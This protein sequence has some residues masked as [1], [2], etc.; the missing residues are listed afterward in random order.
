MS[1]KTK[2]NGQATDQ[3][4]KIIVVALHHIKLKHLH[5]LLD[6]NVGVSYLPSHRQSHGFQSQKLN[7]VTEVCEGCYLIFSK[8][9]I[10]EHILVW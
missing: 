2:Q 7:D 3:P 4:Q 5:Q 1:S 10:M 8:K 9:E 6:A